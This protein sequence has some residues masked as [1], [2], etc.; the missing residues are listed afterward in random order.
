MGCRV[1]VKYVGH[2]RFRDL[3]EIA[4][5]RCQSSLGSHWYSW[6]RYEGL[7][8]NQARDLCH[9]GGGLVHD[10]TMSNTSVGNVGGW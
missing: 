8:F 2:L 6:D 1:P 3:A 10:Q 7:L 9:E 4:R 5:E